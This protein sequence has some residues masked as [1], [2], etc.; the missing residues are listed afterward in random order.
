VQEGKQRVR[1]A[2][3]AK[4]EKRHELARKLAENEKTKI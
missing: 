4:H 3:K 2:I 1:E